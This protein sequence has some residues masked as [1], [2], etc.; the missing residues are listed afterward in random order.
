MLTAAAAATVCALV[1]SA[2]ES[3]A[4]Q[5]RWVRTWDL[6]SLDNWQGRRPPCAGKAAVLDRYPHTSMFLGDLLT[7]GSVELPVEGELIFGEGANM[8]FDHVAKDDCQDATWTHRGPDHWWDPESWADPGFPDP[9]S[10]PVPHINRVPCT[11]DGAVFTH[12]SGSLYRVHLSPPAISVS[13]LSIGNKNF[14]T[15]EFAAFTRTTEGKFR[16]VG[17]SSSSDNAPLYVESPEYCMDITGCPC[18]IETAASICR[19]MSSKCVQPQC[20]NP[21]KMTGF[22]CP[23]CGAEM[24]ISHNG[25]L[26]L[27]SVVEL[28]KDYLNTPANQHVLGYATK[29]DDEHFHVYF[30]AVNENGDYKTASE[31]FKI[32]FEQEL[33]SAKSHMVLITSTGA[34][35]S[36]ILSSVSPHNVAAT[37]ITLAVCLALGVTVYY[38]HKRRATSTFSFMFRRLESSSRRVSVVSDVMGGGRRASTSSIFTYSREGGLRFLNPIFN[39]SMASLAAAGLTAMSSDLVQAPPGEHVEGQRENPMYTAYQN[40]TPEEQQASEDTV[41]ARER[42]LEAAGELVASLDSSPVH[43]KEVKISGVATSDLG[44]IEEE[45]EAKKETND[46]DEGTEDSTEDI[47]DDNKDPLGAVVV[48]FINE[49]KHGRDVLRYHA[50]NEVKPEER[51][52]NPLTSKEE[53]S[54][55]IDGSKSAVTVKVPVDVENIQTDESTSRPELTETA[56]APAQPTSIFELDNSFPSSSSEDDNTSIEIANLEGFTPSV[57]IK[58]DG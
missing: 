57:N 34:I 28:L 13:N 3:E 9:S 55:G 54:S 39:Q 4:V 40:M 15:S 19:I 36:S 29:M 8:V 21:K 5:K 7:L 27:A 33:N 17:V 11:R 43:T 45:R 24:T 48:S 38:L 46:P 18:G 47:D 23:V 20:D 56:A 32:K 2:G 12:T 41:R 50:K 14:T 51:K 25:T 58:F 26:P 1:F 52:E 31:V 53:Y 42:I 30:T 10:S 35:T 37:F 22:C 49:D 44:V 16:F 6:D